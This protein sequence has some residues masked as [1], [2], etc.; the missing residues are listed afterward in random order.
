MRATTH[1]DIYIFNTF[2]EY[3]FLAFM[4]LP[5]LYTCALVLGRIWTFDCPE[6]DRGRERTGRNRGNSLTRLMKVACIRVG[7]PTV[8]IL[9]MVARR[10]ANLVFLPVEHTTLSEV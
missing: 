7:K 6:S 3:P 8:G 9:Q 2:H 1:L 5:L 10:I 4:A